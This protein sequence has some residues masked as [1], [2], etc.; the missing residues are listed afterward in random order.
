M[1]MVIP[2]FTFLGFL[3]GKKAAVF[4]NFDVRRGKHGEHRSPRFVA[5]LSIRKVCSTN[6]SLSGGA[7][8]E[9]SGSRMNRIVCAIPPR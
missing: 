5:H 4:F 2:P 1:A 9:R 3:R 7:S 6:N 8:K